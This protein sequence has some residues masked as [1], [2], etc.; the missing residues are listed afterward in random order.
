MPALI[1]G[2]NAVSFTILVCLFVLFIS[3]VVQ[4]A[5]RVCVEYIAD[6]QEV[7]L[8]RTLQFCLSDQRLSEEALQKSLASPDAILECPMHQLMYFVL[9]L[10]FCFLFT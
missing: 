5:L 9:L 3:V 1:K 8:V 2:K 4:A 6:F 10:S 7:D